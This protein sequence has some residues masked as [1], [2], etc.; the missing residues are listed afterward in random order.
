MLGLF[1]FLFLAVG[2]LA[3]IEIINS[4]LD[5]MLDEAREELLRK[6]NEAMPLNDFKHP[7]SY[8]WLVF[9][10]NSNLECK[11]GALRNLSTLVRNGDV[12]ITNVVI[13]KDGN[14][15]SLEVPLR[16]GQ[17]QMTYEKC[18]V[19]VKKLRQTRRMAVDVQEVQISLK[20]SVISGG[21]PNQCS[22]KIDKVLMTKARRLIINAGGM[23][24]IVSDRIYDCVVEYINGAVREQLMN[25]I[26]ELSNQYLATAELCKK[27]HQSQFSTLHKDPSLK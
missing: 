2:T 27:I 7:F 18:R 21:K 4:G 26:Q 24:D 12:Q 10:I 13:T 8:R 19:T 22:A 14:K 1:L 16:L 23:V 25:R 11:E 5:A 20:L 9:K 15:I 17:F 3:N 6:G